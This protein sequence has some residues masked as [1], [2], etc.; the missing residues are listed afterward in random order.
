MLQVRDYPSCSGFPTYYGQQ[1]AL[2]F[3][4]FW[5]LLWQADSCPTPPT[6]DCPC[7]NPHVLS[8]PEPVALYGKWDFADTAQL[9]ILRWGG[10]AG[11]S[12]WPDASQM[13]LEEGG[14]RV[15]VLER[16]CEDGAELSGEGHLLAVT[17]GEGPWVGEEGGLQKLLKARTGPWRPPEAARSRGPASGFWPPEL[18]CNSRNVCFF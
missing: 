2:S 15:K 5:L 16:K 7:A 4:N 11:W 10:C 8:T 17:M 6:P 18:P 9:T 12:G 1:S 3:I 14:R 13:S